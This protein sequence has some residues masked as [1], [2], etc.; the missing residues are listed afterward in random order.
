MRNGGE[1]S[2][3]EYLAIK[4][5]YTK[6]LQIVDTCTSR[7]FAARWW[8]PHSPFI[9]RGSS[10]SALSFDE[11]SSSSFGE[12]SSSSGMG[13]V[14]HGWG[15]II[16]HGWGVIVQV[17]A[18]SMS[19]LWVALSHHLWVPGRRFWAPCG[20]LFGGGGASFTVDTS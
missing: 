8:W 16:V 7:L 10:L 3:L 12:S 5:E 9:G 1:L 18:C 2:D 15:I 6:Y 4:T 17:G 19:R 20:L 14:I 13:I 11:G